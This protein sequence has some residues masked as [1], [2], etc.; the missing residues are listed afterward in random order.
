[1]DGPIYT[2]ELGQFSKWPARGSTQRRNNRVVGGAM[3]DRPCRWQVGRI[4]IGASSRSPWFSM[5]PN[6]VLKSVVTATAVV[7]PV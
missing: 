5:A 7:D 1:M 3:I 4:F 2:A 6:F